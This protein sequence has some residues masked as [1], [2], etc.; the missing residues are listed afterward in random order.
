MK[1]ASIFSL[2]F[3]MIAS[4]CMISCNQFGTTSSDADSTAVDTTLVDSTV[5]SAVVDT[6]VADTACI[7]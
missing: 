5:D 6:V 2:V 3:V 7:D 1:K 4:M